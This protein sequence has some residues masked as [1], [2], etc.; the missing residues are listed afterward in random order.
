[1]RVDSVHSHIK[2]AI[3]QI[4][5][6]FQAD[7]VRMMEEARKTPK[8]YHDQY[9][10]YAFFKDYSK[11][12][13]LKSIRPGIKAGDPMVV[14]IKALRFESKEKISYKLSF[15]DDWKSIP[16]K[17]EES[18]QVKVASSPLHTAHLCTSLPQNIAIVKS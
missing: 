17:C 1:M 9:L 18:A 6:Y 3:G 11:T 2:T 12:C 4:S 8:S 5:V 7:Y 13:T 10:D 14:H 15:L 16:M